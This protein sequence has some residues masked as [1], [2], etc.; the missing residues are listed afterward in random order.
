MGNS[1]HN[2]VLAE[3]AVN[4]FFCISG[5]L[6]LASAQKGGVL[7]YL[8]RRFLRIFPGYWVSI[9]FI[10]LVAVPVSYLL[11]ASESAWNTQN[12]TQYFLANYD[13]YKL[14]F[15]IPGTIENV[16][17]QAW[18]GSAWTLGYEFLA[19]LLL[20]PFAYLP[21]VKKYQKL[22]IT[23]AFIASL[24][25]YVILTLTDA[26]TNLYWNL[27]RLVPLFLA[28]SVLY[29]WGEY[30]K[31]KFIPVLLG[32]VLTLI[33]H[34]LDIEILLQSF[35]LLFAYS[36]LGLAA[37]IKIYWG[38]Q[39]DLSYGVYIYAFPVQQLLV[40]GGSQ[41]WGIAANTLITLLITMGLAY[42]SWNLVEKPAMSLK[43]LLPAKRQSRKIQQKE[44]SQQ[45]P[46]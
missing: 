25:F 39:N 12:N 29:V 19:Y 14:Q 16:P 1:S 15:N 43:S 26:T 44:S 9:L 10:L 11:G 2:E 13:L 8:W 5:F 36:V 23:L 4:L 37:I 45:C 46:A 38:Y 7:P 40:A 21:G 18:N 27:A 6:I 24:F 35:Q 17:F 28:G 3:L 41:S 32:S 42:L 30:I 31:V 22:T 33:L 20:I 34:Y